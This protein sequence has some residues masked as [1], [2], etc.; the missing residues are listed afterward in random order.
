MGTLSIQAGLIALQNKNYKA[1]HAD[2]IRA[3]QQDPYDP[4]PYFLLGV[5]AADHGNVKKASELFLRAEIS[6][7]YGGL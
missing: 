3:V 5:I 2:S 7:I 4:V 6:S 1:V